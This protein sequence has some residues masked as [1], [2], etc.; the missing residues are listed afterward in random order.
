MDALIRRM[1]EEGYVP[2]SPGSMETSDHA[3]EAELCAN[4]I[5][6]KCGHLGLEYAPFVDRT[7][8]DF[9]AFG[10]CREC[11]YAEEL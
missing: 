3:I 9:R 8:Q 10:Y 7:S 2:G 1:A 5:C 4:G 11:G 6:E